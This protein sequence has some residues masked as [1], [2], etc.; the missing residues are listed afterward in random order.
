MKI[1]HA[2]NLAN[3]GYLAVKVLRNYNID[4]DLLARKPLNSTED[5]K[6]Q[7]S[8]MERTGY[9]DW[10]RFYDTLNSGWKMKILKTMRDKKYDL[11]HAYVELPIFAMISNRKFIAHT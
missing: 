4:A 10:I 2:G 9:P 8:E 7:E 5:P 1:L 6:S 3:F 11:I